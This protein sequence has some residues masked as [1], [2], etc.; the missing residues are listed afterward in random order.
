MKIVLIRP[1]TIV[2]K[3]FLAYGG[4][5]TPAAGLAYISSSLTAAGHATVVIDATGEAL[6]SYQKIGEFNMV[7]IGL[8]VEEIISRIPADVELIGLSCMFS[9]EW[10]YDAQL[11]QRIKTR[12]RNI[13]IV[14]G[15]EHV[16]ADWKNIFEVCPSVD[17][18][19]RGEGEET[20]VEL[21][22]ALQ[23]NQTVEGIA[24]IAFRNSEGVV[25]A[26]PSRKRLK[27]LDELPW[28]AWDQMPLQGYLDAGY[29][30]MMQNRRTMPIVTTRGCP[31]SCS[32][33][34]AP[35]M[36]GSELSYR[37][38]QDVVAEIKHYYEKYKIEHVDFLDI[39]GVINPAWTKEL[40]EALIAADLP[41]TWIFPAGT[42]SEILD[43]ATLKL[44]KESKVA[45]L[46]YAPESGSKKTIKRIKKRFEPD[47]MLRSMKM[48]NKLGIKLRAPLIFGF[49]EQTLYEVWESVLFGFKMIW[50]GVDDVVVYIFGAYPGSQFYK[51]LVASKQIDEQ[52]MLAD[53]TYNEYLK[54]AVVAGIWNQESWSEFIPAWSLGWLR[55]GTMLINQMLRILLRPWRLPMSIYRGLILKKPISIMDQQAYI[56]TQA[57]PYPY[58]Y[59]SLSESDYISLRARQEFAPRRMVLNSKG[60][61]GLTKIRSKA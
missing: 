9:S 30:F 21:A 24:G 46:I 58:D 39:V 34:S 12:F 38:P 57:L 55:I 2:P 19:V 16:T 51:E 6:G 35:Q 52:K 23:Q 26:T 32:F 42:R 40:L 13:P 36:W 20:I 1:N 50:V 53:G 22:E 41:V 25:V 29:S 4:M 17:F 44:C 45:R 14:I 43:E 28:P 33:C 31:F 7:V 37:S 27:K 10:F 48:A 15:G 18:C 54:R 59:A 56:R 49:P 60:F 5:P 47:K 8:T 3:E 11:I 61:E